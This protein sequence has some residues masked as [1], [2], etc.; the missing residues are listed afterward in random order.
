LKNN[1]F[2]DNNQNH[3]K[4]KIKSLL[5]AFFVCI[6][7]AINAQNIHHHIFVNID[8]TN[9]AIEATDSVSI[10]VSFLEKNKGELTFKINA[11]FAV[12]SADANCKI[13]EIKADYLQ[14]SSEIKAKTYLVSFTK[15]N[16]SSFVLPLQYS[17]KVEGEIKEGA[18]EY[19]RGFSETDGIISSE[20]VYFANSTLWVPLFGSALYTF[21]L[22]A[23]IDSAYGIISQGARTKNEI[24]K[25]KKLITYQSEN[26][27]DEFYLIAGKWTEYN[28]HAGSILVQA[29]LRKPDEELANK[30]MGATVGYLELYNRLIGAYPYSKFTLV[31][32]FWETGYGMPSF[33]LLGEKIIRLPFIINSSYPHELLHN[34]WGNSVYVDYSKGNWCEGLTAYMADHLFKEQIGQAN[35]YRRSTLQKFTDFVNESNDFPLAKFQSRNNSAE[36]AVGYG[37]SS[38]VFEMLRYTYGDDVFRKAI[39]TFYA[40]NKFKM[41]SFDEVRITFEK[42]SGKDLK[43]FFN[44]WLNR[45]GAPGIALSN[46]NVKNENSLNIISFT[47]SQTQKEDVFNVMVPVVIFLEGVDSVIVKKINLTKREESFSFSFNQRPARIDVDPQFNVFRRISKEEVPPCI[48]QIFGDKDVVMILPKSS[49]FIKEYTD[50]AEQWKQTQ[51]VQGNNIEIKMD[52]DI[53]ELPNKACWIIGFENKFAKSTEVFSQFNDVMPK[54]TLSQ[55]DSLKKNGAMVY[56]YRNPI[57]NAVTNGFLGST[58]Q[59]MIAGLKRKIVHY[60]KYSYLGFEGD[61][62]TNKLKGEFPVTGS[63]LSFYIK[64]DGKTLPVSAK[65]NVRKALIDNVPN[66]KMK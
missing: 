38:M 50:L 51:Q 63:P 64:Y 7:A 34:Y 53:K 11:G 18:A 66:N 24:R 56:M 36:E 12:K 42:V 62:A 54:E 60:T 49:P 4:M 45:T 58:N 57:N 65:L 46:V 1:I 22:S 29:E 31:E 16:T 39:A 30:Y 6:V 14:N 23:T 61:E 26:P 44:Q 10:P 55:I 43:E 21:N 25:D 8:V 28:S 13:A 5:S 47:L 15:P 40:E 3:I 17:G 52:E 9:K 20:G 33:T 2:L 37:K 48:S 32:N 35:E 59:K 27:S 41:T 19:A